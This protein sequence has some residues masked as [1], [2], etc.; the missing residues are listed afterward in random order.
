MAFPTLFLRALLSNADINQATQVLMILDRRLLADDDSNKKKRETIIQ[1]QQLLIRPTG[2]GIGSPA[3]PRDLGR[4]SFDSSVSHA[5][6]HAKRSTWE[7][8][9]RLCWCGRTT[10]LEQ[11]IL[12]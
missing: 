6:L 4:I 9:V 1:G 2:V 12:L 11:V 3:T 5:I 8:I 10:C 7:Y